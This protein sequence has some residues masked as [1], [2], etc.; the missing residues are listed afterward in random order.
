MFSVDEVAARLSLAS[1]DPEYAEIPAI[2]DAVSVM[3]SRWVGIPT[4]DMWG[5]DVALG[6]TMLAARL[7]RRRNSPAGVEAFNE[8]GA[9]YV[10]RRD[11]DIAMLL[12]LGEWMPPK[13]G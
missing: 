10:S 11:P 13:V 3:V 9:V 4:P 12:G 6:A 2:V 7:H 1:S 8:L 5:D